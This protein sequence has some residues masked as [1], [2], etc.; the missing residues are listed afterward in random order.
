MRSV[1]SDAGL[2]SL[3]SDRAEEIVFHDNSIQPALPRQE[4]PDRVYG[5]RETS[6]FER[7]LSA[8]SKLNTA[9]SGTAA[10]VRD[11]VRC[12]PFRQDGDP[13]LFPFLIL[14]AKSGKGQDSFSSI[15]KQTAFPI[16]TLLRLQEELQKQ[17][18]Y[19]LAWQDGPTVWFL[20]NKGEEWRVSAGF[21]RLFDEEPSYV[22][23]HALIQY[24]KAARIRA[25][26]IFSALSIFGTAGWYP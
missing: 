20:A 3:F 25:N 16:R 21:V 24:C 14:E 6:A 19:H 11:A 26:S 7:A 1:R 10:L 2:N 23:F 5:L 22:R 15:E 8:C 18:R 12:T 9:Q 17:C 4:H 13:L